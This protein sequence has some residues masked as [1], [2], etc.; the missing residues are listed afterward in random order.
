MEEKT[1]CVLGGILYRKC[2]ELTN[3][4]DD[5]AHL[6]GEY[7]GHS[8]SLESARSLPV[9]HVLAEIDV[10]DVTTS[11]DED[12]V[13]V[14]EIHSFYSLLCLDACIAGCPPRHLHFKVKL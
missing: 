7:E 6:L 13:V 3:L 10:K 8:V 2:F 4:I 9:A 12:V 1:R 11:S 5:V 14:T